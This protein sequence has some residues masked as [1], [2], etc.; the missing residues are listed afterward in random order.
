MTLEQ[1]RDLVH[2]LRSRPSDV[3]AVEKRYLADLLEG[4]LRRPDPQPAKP[5]AFCAFC[6]GDGCPR[7]D[8]ER[9]GEGWPV[10]PG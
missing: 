8:A 7:C 2:R 9:D 1:A 10:G 4:T 5:V 3:T 6:Y